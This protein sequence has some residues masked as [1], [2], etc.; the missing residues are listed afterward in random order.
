MFVPVFSNLCL[1]SPR[2]SER[3]I[4]NRFVNNS[5]KRGSNIPLDED[6][7]HSNTS[8]EKDLHELVKRAIESKIFTKQEG[9][10]YKEFRSF[11]RDRLSNLDVSY[12]YKWINKHKRNILWGIRAR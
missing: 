2:D 1:M 3:F 5:G 11:L 9:R 8:L 7:E 4:W 6:T 12:L 10:S